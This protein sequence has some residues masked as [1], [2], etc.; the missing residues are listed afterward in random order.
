MS[1]IIANFVL[2]YLDNKSPVN[3]DAK[4][5]QK[6]MFLYNA[7][8]AGWSVKKRHKSFV[9]YKKHE[10][11]REVL[12]DSYLENFLAHNLDIK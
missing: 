7:V 12:D 3:I 4:T 9:F 6:M 8:E 2:P 10:N 5:F 11:K 1:S